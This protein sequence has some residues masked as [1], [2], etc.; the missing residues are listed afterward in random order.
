MNGEDMIAK[1]HQLIR[2]RTDCNLT[3]AAVHRSMLN[4]AGKRRDHQVAS[5]LAE[6]YYQGAAVP[7]T[8]VLDAF[9]P[10]IVKQY[11]SNIERRSYA[12]AR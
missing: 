7:V 12:R 11:Q 8:D 9:G 4:N 1:A 2:A 3:L 6:S 10:S 5:M